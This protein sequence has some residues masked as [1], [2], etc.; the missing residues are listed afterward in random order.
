MQKEMK[1][2]KRSIINNFMMRNNLQIEENLSED[3]KGL[4]ALN[5]SEIHSNMS[6]SNKS[7]D[8]LPGQTPGF[9][10]KTPILMAS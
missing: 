6:V 9:G 3:E 10:N 2:G 7:S 1:S 4:T 8:T 5:L